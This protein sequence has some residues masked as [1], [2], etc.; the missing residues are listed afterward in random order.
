M[1]APVNPTRGYPWAMTLK[2]KERDPQTDWEWREILVEFGDLHQMEA[3]D[4]MYLGSETVGS[5]RW[6]AAYASRYGMNQVVRSV[7]RAPSR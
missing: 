5:W 6:K 4:T 3:K 7:G 2:R 1:S